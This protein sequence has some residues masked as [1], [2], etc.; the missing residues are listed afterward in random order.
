MNAKELMLDDWVKCL[1]ATHTRKVCA[2]IEAIEEGYSVLVKEDISNWFISREYIEPIP[3]T[4]T[5]LIENGFE[6]QMPYNDYALGDKLAL[7]ECGE[8]F[9]VTGGIGSFNTRLQINYVH[10]LQH[11]LRLIDV[12]KEIEL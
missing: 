6:H 10:E 1:D 2:Q 7:H 5:M 3:L 11:L 8:G 4:F 9:A 12:E